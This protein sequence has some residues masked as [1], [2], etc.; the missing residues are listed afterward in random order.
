MC[1]TARSRITRQCRGTD[2][3]PDRKARN[4]PTLSIRGENYMKRHLASFV[5][6][7]VMVGCGSSSTPRDA[8]RDSQAGAGGSGTGG[9]AGTGGS[10]GSGGIGGAGGSAGTGGAGGSAGTGGA[11]GQRDG[12]ADVRVSSDGSANVV[13]GAVICA[14]GQSC[15]NPSCG[16]CT[17]PG[18]A[19]IQIVC[20]LDASPSGGACNND[21]DCRLFDDYCTGCTCRTLASSEANPTCPGPGVMC[22]R[23]PCEGLAPS[24][25][26]G[27]CS[28]G[29]GDA[30]AM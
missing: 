15:C 18:S 6:L 10:A 2:L 28:A 25:V 24:C 29:R 4:V 20:G 26:Q 22:L 5:L 13:C 27:R 23:A 8:G 21:S 3:A 12:A 17:P 16:I 14:A 1:C 19:C 30:A 11:G 9:N 7:A